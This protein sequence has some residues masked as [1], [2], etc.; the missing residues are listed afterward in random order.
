MSWPGLFVYPQVSFGV[1]KL[2]YRQT[3]FHLKENKISY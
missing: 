2:S 1:K 3:D